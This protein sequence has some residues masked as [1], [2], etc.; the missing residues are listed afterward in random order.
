MYFTNSILGIKRGGRSSTVKDSWIKESSLE[1]LKPLILDII[2]PKIIITLGNSGYKSIAYIFD[3][4]KSVTLKTILSNNPI[5]PESLNIKIFSFFHCGGLGIRN[6][7]FDKQKEDWKIIK[8][9]L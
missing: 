3:Q 7:S 4:P 5:I 2:K 9:Y 8:E 1:F 6:R